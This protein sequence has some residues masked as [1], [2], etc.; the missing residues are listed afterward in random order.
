MLPSSSSLLEVAAPTLEAV[1]LDVLIIITCC[2][3]DR[4]YV[5]GGQVDSVLGAFAW[6]PPSSSSPTDDDSG[7]V[8]SGPGLLEA[9]AVLGVT[10]EYER[11]GGWVDVVWVGDRGVAEQLCV[12]CW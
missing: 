6:P 9:L 10:D 11:V 5:M 2:H 3:A 4:S 7:R 8:L 12:G 1:D